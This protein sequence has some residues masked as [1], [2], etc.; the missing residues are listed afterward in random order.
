MPLSST[1]VGPAEGVGRCVRLETE[2]DGEAVSAAT[3]VGDSIEQ[4]VYRAIYAEVNAK[5]QLQAL[6]LGDVAWLSAREAERAAATNDGRLH[7]SWALW[8][9]RVGSI[10]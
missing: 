8:C 5:L 6:A 7:R 4:V 9:R 1:G 3:T 10:D 2:G